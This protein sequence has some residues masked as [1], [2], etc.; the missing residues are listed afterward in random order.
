MVVTAH[1]L[2]IVVH[3]FFLLF[4]SCDKCELPQQQQYH[5]HEEPS[6]L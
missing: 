3:I 6:S 4:T 1:M 5:H 2:L